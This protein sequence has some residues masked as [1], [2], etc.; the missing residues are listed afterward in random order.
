MKRILRTTDKVDAGR[1]ERRKQSFKR[2]KRKQHRTPKKRIPK[3][4]YGSKEFYDQQQNGQSGQNGQNGQLNPY[5]DPQELHVHQ[6]YYGKIPCAED[7]KNQFFV[8][9]KLRKEYNGS[10]CKICHKTRPTELYIQK[11]VIKYRTKTR[12]LDEA[13]KKYIM[14]EE[15]ENRKR[16]FNEIDLEVEMSSLGL[17]EKFDIRDIE[18]DEELFIDGCFCKFLIGSQS[19]S[20]KILREIPRLVDCND[21]FLEIEDDNG[22]KHVVSTFF[23]F[24]EYMTENQN[25]VPVSTPPRRIKKAT[26]KGPSDLYEEWG[27]KWRFYKEWRNFQV[28]LKQYLPTAVEMRQRFDDS[29]LY[30][31]EEQQ[32]LLKHYVWSKN[33][34]KSY[35]ELTKKLNENRPSFFMP[36]EFIPDTYFKVLNDN[37]Y[38]R[39][40]SCKR[41]KLPNLESRVILC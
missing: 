40:N 6:W 39:Y 5:Y 3:V 32:N 36:A 12:D 24:P 23:V 4:V 8:H 31:H 19:K 22:D 9:Q 26:K 10:Y 15:R 33:P 28:Y 14:E 11:D 13:M 7:H 1:R 30:N 20:G 38:D 41:T 27:Q 35:G 17:S 18:E 21:R 25:L 29:E 34:K 16:S 37:E 2:N